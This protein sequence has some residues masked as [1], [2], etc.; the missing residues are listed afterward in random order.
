MPDCLAVHPDEHLAAIRTETNL[1]AVA[2][3][4]GLDAV[5]PACPGWDVASLLAHVG[6]VHRFWTGTLRQGDGTMGPRPEVPD[7][8]TVDWFEAGAAELLAD[9]EEAGPDRPM[10]N[11][12]GRDQ[13]ARWLYRRMAQE[14][15][16]HRWDA[17][18][19][20]GVQEPIETELATDGVDEVLDVFLPAYLD[21][22]DN[23]GEVSLGGSVH[24]HATD[25]PHGEW[26]LRL[27]KG[28]LLLG[29]SHEKGD[30]AVRA[31]A[32]D[33]LLLL[34]GRVALDAVEVFGDAE[35]LT[36]LRALPIF[37]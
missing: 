8:V 37:E 31:P 6:Q 36:R 26:V 29:H 4:R 25:T 17:Q 16:V 28:E 33:L 9:L 24:L 14:T 20:H 30:V 23:P 22:V 34:W 1:L 12:S 15:S 13:R 32:S 3:R 11:W 19:A 21:D 18:S 2:A 10:W 5:V 35:I 7:S 27:D